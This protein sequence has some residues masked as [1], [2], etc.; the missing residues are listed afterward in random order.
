MKFFLFY[1]K[2]EFKTVRFTR[3]SLA[4]YSYVFVVLAS[5]FMVT[6]RESGACGSVEGSNN[7][8]DGIEEQRGVCIHGDLLNMNDTNLRSA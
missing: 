3:T 5:H 2:Q 8:L 1:F 7:S 4:N 6:S